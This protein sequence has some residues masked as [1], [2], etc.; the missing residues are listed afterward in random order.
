MNIEE[1][2]IKSAIEYY[3]ANP[4]LKTRKRGSVN[5]RHAVFIQ[6]YKMGY[7]YQKAAD[8][9]DRDHATAFHAI[10]KHNDLMQV[11]KSYRLQY[12]QFTELFYQN[13]SSKSCYIAGKIS[14]LSE[15]EYT[16]NFKRGEEKVKFLGMYPVNPVT[17]PHLHDKTWESYVCESMKAMLSCGCVYA[18]DGWEESTGAK[19]EIDL[20]IKLGKKVIYETPQRL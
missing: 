14:G 4:Y 6:L 8:I 19:I 1:I 15:D 9:F 11:D 5:A 7:T 10:K 16:S 20:A 12:Q 2:A 3:N 18:L 13:L 17:L